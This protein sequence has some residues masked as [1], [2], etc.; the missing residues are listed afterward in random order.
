MLWFIVKLFALAFYSNLPAKSIDF[1]YFVFA[2][3]N[4]A[5][6]AKKTHIIRGKNLMSHNSSPEL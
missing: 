1:R 2:R 4:F 6:N 5:V 3:V